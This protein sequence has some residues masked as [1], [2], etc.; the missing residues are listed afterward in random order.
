[1]SGTT[2][3]RAS[4]PSRCACTFGGRLAPARSARRRTGRPA[5]RCGRAPCRSPG[6]R[7]RS[8]RAAAATRRRP[9][10]APPTAARARARAQSSSATCGAYGWISDTAVSAAKRARRIVRRLRELVHE[11]HHR[12][13]RRVEDEAAAD[14]VGDARDRLVRLAR[15][16]RVDGSPARRGCA[17]A[18]CTTPPQPADEPHASPR[19]R[20]RVHS[21]SWSAGPMEEDVEA[22]RVGAVSASISSSGRSRCPSTSTSS[23]RRAAPSPGGRAAGTARGT[24]AGRGR[25]A[26]S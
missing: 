25:S 22:N 26:P 12:G 6:A 13:D 8:C 2:I 16:R 20:R 10:T 24:R 15:E 5:P 7:A 14:V 17:A 21:M 23:C 4:S 1:M 3:A 18:S 9:A 11:L 19:S